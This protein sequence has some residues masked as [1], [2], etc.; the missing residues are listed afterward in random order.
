MYRKSDQSTITPEKFELPFEGKLSSENRWVI[1]AE[2]IPWSEFEEEYAQN[3]SEKMGAIAKPFRMALG[4]LIIKEKL[5]ISDRETI[6]QIKENPYLQ[7]FLG[8]SSYSNEAPFDA[9]LM[10]YFRERIDLNLVNEVNEKMV[11]NFRKKE[12]QESEKKTNQVKEK[13]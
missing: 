10:V 6:E 2:L 4:A 3:F 11:K 7:Y 12:E 8:M 5:G 13:K 1:M 9:S